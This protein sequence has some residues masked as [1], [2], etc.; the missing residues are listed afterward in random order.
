M[1][2]KLKAEKNYIT[3]NKKSW[4]DRVESHLKSEFYDNEAFLNGKSSL[5]SIELNLLGDVQ[6]KSILHLQCH[7]GQDSLSLARLGAHVTGVDFSEKAIE[8]A[9]GMAT[10]LKLSTQFVCSDIYK[11]DTCLE[12]KY[13]IIFTSYG[14][15]GWLP[16]LNKWA[17]IIS[18][19]LKPNG[20]FIMVDFHPLLWMYDNNMEQLAYSYFNDGAIVEEEKGTYAD[21]L[22]DIVIKTVGWN[23]P[24]SEIFTS[25]K[26]NN[27]K[28][29][30]FLEYNYAPYNCFKGLEEVEQGKFMFKKFGDKFPILYALQARF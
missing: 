1:L 30:T 7:F 2:D 10:N 24:I 5:N 18:H 12:G 22:A 25:L 29:D 8:T 27:L 11:L 4:N 21:P 28:M 15:I 17:H 20:K 13:D 16:D 19:F 14:T 3:L 26:N 9:Q 6:N 23:H